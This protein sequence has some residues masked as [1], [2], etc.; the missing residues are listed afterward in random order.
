[1]MMS[2]K[3]LV[4]PKECTFELLPTLSYFGWH[5]TPTN[6]CIGVILDNVVTFKQDQSSVNN[7]LYKFL[8]SSTTKEEELVKKLLRL[9][10]CEIPAFTEWGTTT[11]PLNTHFKSC[12]VGKEGVRMLRNCD[13][14]ECLFG[15]ICSTNN[16]EARTAKMIQSL[17]ENYGSL[18]YTSPET[19]GNGGK[20]YFSFPTLQQMQAITETKLKDLGF[21]YKS[22]LICAAIKQ[23]A[24]KGG[25]DWLLSLKALSRDKAVVEITTLSGVGKKVAD[26]VCLY[27]LDKLDAVPIDTHMWTL[28]QK[29]SPALQDKALSPKLYD[30]AGNFFRERFGPMA[31]WAECILFASAIEARKNGKNKRD[32]D[33]ETTNKPKKKKTKK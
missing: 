2:W 18:L 8:K 7:L 13:I 29:Y 21:G 30:Q 6:E 31:G 16:N 19:D 11:H 14:L 4:V 22:R 27:S 9:D 12:A 28:A 5:V 1:V 3:S 17:R 15:T 20:K 10:S 23:V 26:C 33:T 25:L 32:T 24:D